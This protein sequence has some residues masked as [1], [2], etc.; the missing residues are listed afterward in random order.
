MCVSELSVPVAA[1]KGGHQRALQMQL[2]TTTICASGRVAPVERREAS[3]A[4]G[5]KV[6]MQSTKVRTQGS[7]VRASIS[8]SPYRMQ[9]QHATTPPPAAPPTG[10]IRPA[11]HNA[12]INAT[13]VRAHSFLHKAS[14]HNSYAAVVTMFM[15]SLVNVGGLHVH[16]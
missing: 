15:Y 2:V 5:A 13:W 7:K 12:A 1:E 10:Y 14:P 3:Q 9:Q 4:Q 6:R 11:Q 16:M 8:T